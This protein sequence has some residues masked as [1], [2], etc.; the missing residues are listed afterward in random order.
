MAHAEDS[1]K[2]AKQLCHAG[3]YE[4]AVPRFVKALEDYENVESVVW[5]AREFPDKT[6]AMSLLE[7]T[8]AKGMSSRSW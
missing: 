2:K 6:L 3:Q 4:R 1:L 5:K 8:E 7:A